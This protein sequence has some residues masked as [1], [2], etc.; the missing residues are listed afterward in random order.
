MANKVDVTMLEKLGINPNQVDLS[1]VKATT[2]KTTTTPNQEE[3]KTEARESILEANTSLGSEVT[4]MAIVR[5]GFLK[6]DKGN[7]KLENGKKV[8][9]FVPKSMKGHFTIDKQKDGT[10]IVSKVNY[11][12]ESY[13]VVD[14]VELGKKQTSK[15]LEK[16]L[17]K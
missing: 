9:R 16:E 6:D 3:L 7:F 17:N 14:Y 13:K 15:E 11:Y 1:E 12:T 4:F 5:D 8:A 2:T 10:F